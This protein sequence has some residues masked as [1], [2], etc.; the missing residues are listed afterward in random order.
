M[1]KHEILI[2]NGPNLGHLGKRQPDIYGSQ[3]MNDVPALVDTLLGARAKDIELSFF[4]ANGEGEL[5]DRLELAREQ[6]IAGIVFNAGAYTHTSLAL[7][8]CLAW[9][10]IPCIE[11]HISNVWA[12]PETIRHQSFMAA[13]VVGVIAGFGIDS[14]ALAVAALLN[15]FERS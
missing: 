14:Y 2:L 13:Q 6:G 3:G 4:Q 11:V 10:G 9:I 7:A 5:I 15:R 1:A 12:R 8:D